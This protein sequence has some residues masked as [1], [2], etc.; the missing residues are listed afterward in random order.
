[1]REQIKQTMA[2]FQ[3]G[4]ISA[5]EARKIIGLIVRS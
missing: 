2:R 3:A 5:E 1:M 4:L